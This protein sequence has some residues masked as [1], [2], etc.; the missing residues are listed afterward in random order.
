MSQ[1]FGVIHILAASEATEYRLPKQSAILA[2]SRVGQNI[3]RQGRPGM[4][5]PL[6]EFA[7]S[8]TWKP[9]IKNSAERWTMSVAFIRICAAMHVRATAVP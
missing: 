7:A 5:A 8:P 3:T 1:T 9:L 6:R 4:E 2:G